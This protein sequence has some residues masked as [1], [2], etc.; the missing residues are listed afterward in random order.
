MNS[1]I[2]KAMLSG[3][4][5]ILGVA[6]TYVVFASLFIYLY[7]TWTIDPFYAH[8]PWVVGVAL[9]LYLRFLGLHKHVL[10]TTIDRKRLY[11]GI[12]LFVIAALIFSGGVYT[13]VPF[14]G[15]L[16]FIA[17]MLSMH[18][19]LFG[20]KSWREYTFP[21]VYL[22]FA[23]PLPYLSEFSGLLQVGIAKLSYT[24]FHGLGY[25]ITQ[26]G[27]TLHIQEAS[28]QIAANCTGITSWLVLF[29]L[30]TFF[31]YF[32]NIGLH[33]KIIVALLIVPIALVS[34]FIRVSILLYLGA[35]R[36]QAFAMAYWHDFGGLTFYLLSCIAVFLCMI[37]I[38]KYG[39]NE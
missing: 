9:L 17:W 31:L 24:L 13:R 4:V 21:F 37:F 2:Q 36:G 22:L 38:K 35:H 34:N 16:G 6:I 23:V 20:T 18:C 29:S 12:S 25:A 26:Q 8:G 5:V 28:F 27:I 39:S 10:L 3:L 33:K 32:I 1:N 7:Q 30:M 14:L 15:G 19:I 11:I